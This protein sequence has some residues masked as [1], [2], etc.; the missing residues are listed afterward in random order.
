MLIKI[1]SRKENFNENAMSFNKLMWD[2]LRLK[3]DLTK[4]LEVLFC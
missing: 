2:K 4:L 1:N 3:V